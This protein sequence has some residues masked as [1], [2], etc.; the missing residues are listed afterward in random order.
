MVFSGRAAVVVLDGFGPIPSKEWSIC[1]QV[2]RTLDDGTRKVLLDGRK[3]VL[4]IASLAPTSHGVA[5]H[6]ARTEGSDWLV[7]L[8]EVKTAHARTCELLEQAPMGPSTVAGLVR[9]TAHRERY[10]PWTANTP[11]LFRLRQENPTWVTRTAGVFTGFEELS[12]EIMGNSDT[13]HQ[14]IFNLM[15]ARQVPAIISRMV[16]DGS[17]FSNED[18]NRDLCRARDGATVVVKTLLSGE[19]GDDGYVHSAYK[20]L[21]AFFKLYFEVLKLPASSLQIEAVLDGRDSPYYSSLRYEEKDGVLRYG[22]LRKLRKVLRGFG[23]ESCLSWIMGRQFMDRDYKGGMIRKEYELVARNAGR[24]VGDVDE[25]FDLIDRDH[26]AGFVD[27]VIEPIVIGS[28]RPVGDGT[29]FFNAIFRSDRQE[30]ITAA[31]LGHTEFIRRQAE[32]KKRLDTWEDFSWISPFSALTH[33]SMVDYHE[34]FPGRGAR[35][36]YKDRPH[37]H[38]VLH[39]LNREKPGFRFLF[40]TEGVKEKHMGLFS[41]GR[42]STPLLPAETQKI[43]PTHGKEQGVNNDNDLWKVPKMRHPEIAAELDRALGDREFDLVACNF[44]GADMIGHLIENHFD[45]CVETIESLDHAL[46]RIVTTAR[47]NGWVLL[48]TSDHGNVEHCG[49]DH[50]NNDV[51]TTLVLPDESRFEAVPPPNCSGRLFDV[52]HTILEVLGV[53]LSALQ[54]P[55]IP[56]HISRDPRRLVGCALVRTRS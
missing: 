33:W 26:A 12:P 13:G 51:L 38:N 9:E 4:V 44:P 16:E 29:V 54:A 11:F 43:I 48:V 52:S 18:L 49:P 39:L 17:F 22:Y 53:S 20:H 19:F 45:A 6:M 15:V 35:S 36:L 41:R 21:L 30:P 32:Q 27:P 46:A 55:P 14:Q 50:G 34:E 28:P 31:L 7:L 37:E 42:R 5:W 24:K 23:A 25:A 8:D 3:Q 10:A 56:E 1:E 40:L 47:A 2:F